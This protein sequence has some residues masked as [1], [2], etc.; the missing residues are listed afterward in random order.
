MKSLFFIGLLSLSAC[1]DLASLDPMV[2]LS[3]AQRCVNEDSNPDVDV[4]FRQDI[5]TMF[6]PSVGKA[7]CS[8][9]MPGHPDAIGIEESGLDLTDFSSLMAGGN[10]SGSSIVIENEPCES[11]L[12]QKLSSGPPFGTRMP[13]DGPPFLDKAQLRLIADWIAEGANDN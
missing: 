6:S 1:L 9:H 7:S 8:C 4:S 12:W 11:V 2:G 13:F 10:N 3:S 5:Q